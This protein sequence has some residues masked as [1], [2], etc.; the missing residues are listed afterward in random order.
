MGKEEA[1]ATRVLT[2]MANGFEDIEAVAPIDVLTRAGVEVTIAGLP[3]GFD[4][5]RLR[6]FRRSSHDNR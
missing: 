1:M 2:L 5:R 3:G 6:Y 4:S